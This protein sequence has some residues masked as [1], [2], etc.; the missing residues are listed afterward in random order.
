MPI[1][2]H[3]HRT[4]KSGDHTQATVLGN[5]RQHSIT[6]SA[7]ELAGVLC[8]PWRTVARALQRLTAGGDVRQILYTHQDSRYRKRSTVRYQAEAH[9][10]PA[11]PAWLT[12]GEVFPIIGAKRIQGRASQG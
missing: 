3:E 6:L 10:A 9:Q 4:I 8:W 12:G 11:L 2:N 1:T 7:V 5:L